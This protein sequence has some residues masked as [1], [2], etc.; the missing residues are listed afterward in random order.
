M[1]VLYVRLQSLHTPSLEAAR[2]LSN[3][4]PQPFLV[5]F[6][7]SHG[8]GL[9]KVWGNR[10]SYSPRALPPRS[11]DPNAHGTIEKLQTLHEHFLFPAKQSTPSTTSTMSGYDLVILN[12][13]GDF[14]ADTEVF[15][16]QDPY[17]I[18]K[19]D[20]SQVKSKVRHTDRGVHCISPLRVGPYYKSF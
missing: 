16:R 20:E 14:A 6:L 9:C 4:A 1:G 2:F 3:L 19:T 15:G 8:L 12:V 11:T 18:F 10:L 7:S 5:G 17:M 13:A